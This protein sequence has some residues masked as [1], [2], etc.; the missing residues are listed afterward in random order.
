M[1]PHV[2]KWEMLKRGFPVRV[3]RCGA[4]KASHIQIGDKTLS[5][6]GNLITWSASQDTADIKSVGMDIATGRLRL[7]VGGA[8]KN[9]MVDG[10]GFTGTLS[11]INS[12]GGFDISLTAGEALVQ[13]E[14]V[15]AGAADDTVVKAPLSDNQPLGMVFANADNAAPVWLTVA[16]RGYAKPLDAVTAVRGYH[17]VT[18]DSVAG[19][20][21]QSAVIPV[22]AVH[23]RE[24]GHYIRNGSGAGVAAVAVVHFN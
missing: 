24:I 9:V 14:A 1:K 3:C 12:L 22:A 19:R 18:S 8:A 20:V 16:G 17:L 11:R 5:L 10:D 7:Y 6:S 21:D 23:F 2:H 4:I 15:V 13:G